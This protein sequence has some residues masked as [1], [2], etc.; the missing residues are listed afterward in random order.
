ML[1]VPQSSAVG[2]CAGR[3]DGR[4]DPEMELNEAQTRAVLINQQLLAAGWKLSDR[5]QVGFEIPVEGYDPT[6]WQGFT[7]FCL[8]RPEQDVLTVVEAKRCS[9]NPREGE[10]QLRQYI[11][12]IA[13]RQSFAPFGFMTN[14]LRCWF[15]E[16]GEAHLRD[17]GPILVNEV[18]G[19]VWSGYVGWKKT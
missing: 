17:H 6:P 9:R 16:V 13:A 5:T 3:L 4:S 18:Q 2:L 10:E 8:F 19:A 1:G 14:G 15:W 12:I 11:E 7:D